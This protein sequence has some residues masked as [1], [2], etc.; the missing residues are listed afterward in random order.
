MCGSHSSSPF[1][2][3]RPA[4]WHTVNEG[5]FKLKEA[6][7]MKE[8]RATLMGLRRAVAGTAGHGHRFLSFTDNMSGL[9][10]FDRGRSRSYDLVHWRRC[11]VGCS[12]LGDLA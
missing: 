6:I 12:T 3:E 4:R 9:L 7:H 1:S 2:M 8:G 10:A 5:N 11:V